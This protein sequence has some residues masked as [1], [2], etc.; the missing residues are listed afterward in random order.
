MKDKIVR[1]E[2]DQNVQSGIPSTTGCIPVGLQRHQFP[3]R[4]IKEIHQGKNYFPYFL[5]QQF[6]LVSENKTY[7]Q[8]CFYKIVKLAVV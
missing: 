2:K 6:H 1:N 4:R 3:E 7:L 8:C 5:M